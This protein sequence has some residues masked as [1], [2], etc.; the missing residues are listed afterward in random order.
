MN[1]N[2]PPQRRS[3][4]G[5]VIALLLL[6]VMVLLGG[7]AFLGLGLYM[8]ARSKVAEAHVR[9]QRQLA[10]EHARL[11]REHVDAVPADEPP[12]VTSWAEMEQLQSAEPP[13]AAPP[14]PPE[15][16]PIRVA[17]REIRVTL[18][19][20]GHITVDGAAV[21]RDKFR[22]FL[23]G[24][25][26]GRESDLKIVVAAHPQCRFEYVATVLEACQKVG[27]PDVRIMPSEERPP[28]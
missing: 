26:K 13:Q 5:C 27:V 6:F 28:E 18:D 22:E 20:D 25:G 2:N 15:P 24:A 1:Y 23:E 4:A 12:A 7:L 14:A 17:N 10:E 9:V 16:E 19:A 8:T 21:E 3:S 11:A